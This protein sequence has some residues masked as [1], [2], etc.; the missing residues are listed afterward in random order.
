MVALGQKGSVEQAI[1]RDRIRNALKRYENKPSDSHEHGVVRSVNSDGS[2]EVLLPG[3]VATTRCANFC[4]A[5]VGD[6]VKVVINANGRCDAIGRL[7]GDLGGGEVASAL[8][9][10]VGSATEL[11]T[12]VTIGSNYSSITPYGSYLMGNCLRAGFS[13][14][15]K[16]SVSGDIENEVA[17]TFKIKHGGRIRYG[18]TVSFTGG[19]N[20]GNASFVTGDVSNDGEY[21]TFNVYL[22]AVAQSSSEF[23]AYFIIPV[24]RSIDIPEYG[25]GSSGGSGGSGGGITTETDPTVPS[26]AKQP[27]KPTYTASEV[28][29][30]AKGAAS[31]ALADAKAYTDQRLSDFNPPSGGG[32]S[33]I[34]AMEVDGDGNLYV[35]YENGG[36]VPSFELDE[37]GNLYYVIEE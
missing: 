22:T 2:Y 28:G 27:Q 3:D 30:D 20:S 14:K 15:R 6:V 10:T 31:S 7:G 18:F 17:C 23:N 13:A 35:V 32:S 11:E 16:S 8:K 25:S 9:S 33:G 5:A 29:A 26:W 1:G 37:S 36:G 19:G 4:T 21:L 24:S 34:F 12:T